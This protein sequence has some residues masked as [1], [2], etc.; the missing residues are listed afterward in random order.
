MIFWMNALRLWRII[1]FMEPKIDVKIDKLEKKIKKLDE[2]SRRN[3]SHITELLRQIDLEK[4]NPMNL[5]YVDGKLCWRSG[6]ID[7]SAFISTAKAIQGNSKDNKEKNDYYKILFLTLDNVSQNNRQDL[8]NEVVKELKISTVKIKKQ[9][10]IDLMAEIK[11][12][13][14]ELDMLIESANN[15]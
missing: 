4:S 2:E 5:L 12:L 13:K 6:K 3:K 8:L 1:E 15:S 9:E 14:E 7:E 10:L 11:K